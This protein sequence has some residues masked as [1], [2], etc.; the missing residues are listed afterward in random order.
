M[1]VKIDLVDDSAETNYRLEARKLAS[2]CHGPERTGHSGLPGILLAQ[3]GIIFLESVIVDEDIRKYVPGRLLEDR[4][5][6][7]RQ[8]DSD[9]CNEIQNVL[10]KGA[11]GM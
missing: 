4:N 7:M 1:N 2:A 8:K 3:D 10:M 6:K 5:L 11:R 9:I